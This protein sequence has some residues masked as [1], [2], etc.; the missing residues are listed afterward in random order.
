MDDVESSPGPA[1]SFDNGETSPS[2]SNGDS[3]VDEVQEVSVVAR[4][5]EVQEVIVVDRV[6]VDVIIS[7][8]DEVVVLRRLATTTA[9]I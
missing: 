8:L 6:D 4:L 5:D 9:G 3:D 2:L 1:D 7:V